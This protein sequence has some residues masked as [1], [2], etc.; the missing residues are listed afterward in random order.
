MATGDDDDVQT[1]FEKRLIL[2]VEKETM[3]DGKPRVG[4]KK[5]WTYIS[6]VVKESS[7]LY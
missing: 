5:N 1:K 6:S 3:I 4:V 2:A 7:R